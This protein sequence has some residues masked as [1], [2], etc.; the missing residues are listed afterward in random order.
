MSTTQSYRSFNNTI[1]SSGSMAGNLTSSVQS[2]DNCVRF[3]IQ[4]FWS[5][6]SP[7]GTIG[8]QVSNDQTNWTSVDSQTVSTNSGTYGLNYDNPGFPYVQLYYTYSSGTGTLN[9]TIAGKFE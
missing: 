8:V 5:G 4:A 3:F 2:L 9:A 1:L 6:T 7:S